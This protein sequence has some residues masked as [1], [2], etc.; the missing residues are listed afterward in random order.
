M[1]Q[2]LADNNAVVLSGLGTKGAPTENSADN[3]FPCGPSKIITN[4][5]E[6]LSFQANFG[7]KDNYELLNGLRENGGTIGELYYA[8]KGG[9][10]F[11]AIGTPTV[12]V[13]WSSVA[14]GD[15]T[16]WTAT[17]DFEWDTNSLDEPFC[18][19]GDIFGCNPVA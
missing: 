2:A 12:S 14:I 19:L 1:N 6:T 4:F 10:V 7:N 16:I 13:S 17:L 18:A 11:K 15:D 3:P 8:T 9:L 5:T